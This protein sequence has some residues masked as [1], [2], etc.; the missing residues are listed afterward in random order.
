MK[1]R[2]IELH[3]HLDGAI[4]P[5][6]AKDLAALQKIKLPYKDERE[7][8]KALMVSKD[9]RSLN[10]F[11]ECFKLPCSLLQTKEGIARAVYLVQ[12]NIKRQGVVYAEIRFAPQLHMDKGLTMREVIESALDGLKKS[13]L[14]CNLILCCIVNGTF[15]SFASLKTSINCSVLYNASAPA[16]SSATTP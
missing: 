3:L 15:N 8:E 12:E 1:K 2:Y 13:D 7:L 9:C 6:I 11:L 5:D 14:K 4:T 10:E 16:K